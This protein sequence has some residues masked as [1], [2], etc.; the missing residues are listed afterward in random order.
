MSAKTAKTAKTAKAKESAGAARALIIVPTYNELENLPLLVEAVFAVV[1]EVHIL[2]VDD[3][4]PDG[5]GALADRL[6]AEDP[7]VSVLHRKGKLGLGTA[8]IAGFPLGA[9]TR[10]PV[11]PRDGRRLQPPAEVPARP[12][13]GGRGRRRSGPG[14]ALCPRRRHRRL[15]R[16][17]A[18]HQPWRQPL[19]PRRAVAALSRPHRRLQVLQPTRARDHR[20]ETPCARRVTR[21]RSS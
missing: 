3:G 1:P 6:A 7:R 8:Y 12:A 18:G 16:D 10:L 9:R 2:V 20:P 17:P 4:S 13:R 11:H 14:H 19:R 5:T 15:G 21:S